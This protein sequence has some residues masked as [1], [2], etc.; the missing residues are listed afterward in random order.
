MSLHSL[1]LQLETRGA[2]YRTS[3]RDLLLGLV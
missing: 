3:D 2:R 1:Q